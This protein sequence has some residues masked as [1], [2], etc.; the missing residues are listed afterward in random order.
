MTK[1]VPDPR[2]RSLYNHSTI[3]Y[4]VYSLISYI[5]FDNYFS[6]KLRKIIY[7]YDLIFGN[8]SKIVVSRLT[9][10]L[11]YRKTCLTLYASSQFDIKL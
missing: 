10:T 1:I 2:W 11:G 8:I 6:Y 3:V 5:L 4:T 9:G 7:S